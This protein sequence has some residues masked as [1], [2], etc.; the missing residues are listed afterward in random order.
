M[1]DVTRLDIY[2]KDVRAL[3]DVNPL[4]LELEF[5]PLNENTVDNNVED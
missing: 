2:F 1:R 5:V 4:D 3:S